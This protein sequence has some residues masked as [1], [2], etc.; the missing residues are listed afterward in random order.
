[1]IS[2]VFQGTIY[3]NK[4]LIRESTFIDPSMCKVL[5]SEHSQVLCKLDQPN[6]STALGCTA[7]Y[8]LQ[9][10]RIYTKARTLDSIIRDKKYQIKR[11]LKEQIKQE[12]K[13]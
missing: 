3:P 5:K 2:L 13:K 6:P 7:P 11:K 1:M 8:G 12:N 4:I 9:E 10:Q